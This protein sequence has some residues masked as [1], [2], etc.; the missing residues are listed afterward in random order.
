MCDYLKEKEE[1]LETLTV[2]QLIEILNKYDKSMKVM[3]TWEGTINSIQEQFIY[4]SVTGTLY[5]DA[6][7]L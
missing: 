3:T 2:G 7:H 4:T 5:I 6:D 1:Y